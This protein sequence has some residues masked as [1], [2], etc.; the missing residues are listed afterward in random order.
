MPLY[1]DDAQVRDVLRMEDLIPVM[2]KALIDFSARRVVQPLRTS[3]EVKPHDGYFFLMPAYGDG[4][5]AKIVTLYYGNAERGLPAHFA[6]IFLLDPETGEPLA[7]MDGTYIT[8]MRTAAVSAAATKPLAPAEAKVL[9][10]IG[11]GVQARS[12]FEALSLIR[13][14]E[15]IRVSDRTPEVAQRFADEIG[16]RA[17]S[18]EEAIRGADV[19]VT[20]TSA[21]EPVLKNPVVML[22]RWE[23]RGRTGASWM[24]RRWKTC[25]MLT[26]ARR[27]WSNREM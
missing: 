15:E 4:L 21:T 26:R 19:V 7:V 8:E 25:S 6:T 18:A 24:T 1:L 3:F 20:V 14:F 17:T 10:I 23:R 27:R 16:A 2:E 9:A 11:C 22:M 12:H 13:E 5:G